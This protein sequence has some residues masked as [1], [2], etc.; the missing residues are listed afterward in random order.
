MWWIFLREFVTHE[1]SHQWNLL[2]RAGF[3]VEIGQ[4]QHHQVQRSQND[5]NWCMLV[6]VYYVVYVV[7]CI[8]V[9]YVICCW[10]KKTR[11]GDLL[12][13]GITVASASHLIITKLS[14][15]TILSLFKSWIVCILCITWCVCF[16][17][18]RHRE[19]L[20]VDRF[21]ILDLI[22]DDCEVVR[23]V[24]KVGQVQRIVPVLRIELAHVYST[25]TLYTAERRDLHQ[26][27]P[28]DFPKTRDA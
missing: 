4:P 22:V 8:F 3:L 24:D 26:Q 9:V 25:C 17:F 16:R 14:S 7:C 5:C 12:S 11:G 27:R 10:L 6:V 20:L 15:W 28:R 18:D 19:V 21:L 23:P 1:K 13:G 2:G